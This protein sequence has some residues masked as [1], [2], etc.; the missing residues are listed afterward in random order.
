M[1]NAISSAS[2]CHVVIDGVGLYDVICWTIGD[3]GVPTP[4]INRDGVLT[5]FYMLPLH[6]NP[7][8]YTGTAAEHVQGIR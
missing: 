4:W 8:F 2:P 5:S 7:T 3:N 6:L 1:P